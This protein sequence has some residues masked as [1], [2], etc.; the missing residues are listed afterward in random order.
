MMKVAGGAPM[1]VKQ[2][3]TKEKLEKNAFGSPQRGN[4]NCTNTVTK[5]TKTVM[6]ANVVCTSP[7]STGSVHI[8]ATS[9]T[10]YTGHVVSK[11]TQR[12]KEMEVTMDM[13]GK[14]LGADCG[15]VK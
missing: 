8:E 4:Q 1:T 15:D 7:P 13:T 14:W 6:E 9:S 2:C 11:S 10:S 3:M 12:G 5:N